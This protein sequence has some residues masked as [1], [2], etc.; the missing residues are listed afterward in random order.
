MRLE[1]L[2]PMQK[3]ESLEKRLAELKKVLRMLQKKLKTITRLAAL[4]P[5][6]SVRTSPSMY[7]KGNVIVPASK[8]VMPKIEMS[9]T[10]IKFAVRYNVMRLPEI[11]SRAVWLSALPVR[12]RLLSPSR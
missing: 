9:L 8:I 2:S 12:A 10:A 3:M 6:I 4:N 1:Q 5:Q 11:R 7:A